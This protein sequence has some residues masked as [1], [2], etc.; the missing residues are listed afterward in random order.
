M[1][2]WWQDSGLHEIGRETGVKDSEQCRPLGT[3]GPRGSSQRDDE[4]LCPESKIMMMINLLDIKWIEF[5]G[6][7]DE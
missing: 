1:E 7:G 4:E 3:D 2:S 5:K 6:T